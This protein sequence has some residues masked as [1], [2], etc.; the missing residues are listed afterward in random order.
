MISVGLDISSKKITIIEVLQ[1]RKGMSIKNAIDFNKNR[2]PP[3]IIAFPTTTIVA[4]KHSQKLNSRTHKRKPAN[5][6]S[7]KIFR[8][9]A[10]F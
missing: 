7:N 8:F 1:T 9:S 2:N 4:A 5:M 10:F 6:K 3:T